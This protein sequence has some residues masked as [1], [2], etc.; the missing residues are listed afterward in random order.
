MTNWEICGWIVFTLGMV[1]LAIPAIRAINRVIKIC[2][3]GTQKYSLEEKYSQDQEDLET[4]GKY[5]AVSYT[6]PSLAEHK[7]TKFDPKPTNS[8]ARIQEKLDKEIKFLEKDRESKNK[9]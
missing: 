6:P 1:V 7:D 9:D 3:D 5:K 2:G 8:M 4:K